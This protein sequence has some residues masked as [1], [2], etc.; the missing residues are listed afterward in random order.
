MKETHDGKSTRIGG[1][2]VY[3]KQCHCFAGDK[4]EGSCKI[5]GFCSSEYWDCR[6]LGCDIVW[7]VGIQGVTT[8]CL[9]GSTGRAILCPL[10]QLRRPQSELKPDLGFG[11]SKTYAGR[12]DDVWEGQE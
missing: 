3:Q 10:S 5:L 6:L 8:C 2:S 1:S 7:P 4:E 11:C 12:K 9:Q